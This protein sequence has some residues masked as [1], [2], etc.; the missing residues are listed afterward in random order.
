MQRAVISQMHLN[1]PPDIEIWKVFSDDLRATRY[2]T[3]RSG[4][5]TAKKVPRNFDRYFPRRCYVS[6]QLPQ[7]QL[8]KFTVGGE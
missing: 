7:Q 2:V 3:C 1:R 5:R 4:F 6:K 8:E